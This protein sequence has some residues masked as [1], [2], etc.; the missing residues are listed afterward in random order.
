[1]SLAEDFIKALPSDVQTEMA[2]L[3]AILNDKKAFSVARTF[4]MTV[5][6][7]LRAKKV[8]SRSE[9]EEAGGLNY[10]VSL[11][12]TA[13]SMANMEFHCRIVTEMWMR[14][15]LI[16]V[17]QTNVSRSYDLSFDV[18]DVL[19]KSQGELSKITE[20]LQYRKPVS[21]GELA[22]QVISDMEKGDNDLFYVPTGISDIDN[23]VKMCASDLI[24]LAARPGMGKTSLIVNFMLNLGIAGRRGMFFS[25]EMPSIQIV[26]K[27][28]SLDSGV[29]Y[30]KIRERKCDPY[31]RER[32]SESYGRIKHM[33]SMIN[34][35]SN[36]TIEEIKAL[37]ISENSK[38]PIEYVII[39]FLQTTKPSIKGTRDQEIGHMTRNAKAMAKEL[40]VPVIYLSQLSR[41]VEKRGGDKR[42]VLSDLRDS[43]NIEQD[44]DTVM[45]MYRPEY[46]GINEDEHGGSTK[47]ICEIDFAKNRHGGTG[48]VQVRCRMD[49]GRFFDMN[50]PSDMVPPVE[51]QMDLF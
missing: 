22:F 34:D 16:T 30:W 20:K 23:E 12:N 9:L 41:D 11:A 15:L 21:V 42:P 35:T 2:I 37:A 29:P 38:E 14:R 24:I 5:S 33:T 8:G 40:G 32:L 28:L 47:G 27:M 13:S 31:E 17:S 7:S 19:A 46:Y 43:G 1:M 4:L 50:T 45:F 48:M 36:M 49:I 18:F 51:E 10:L 39:D 26:Q 25:L 6:N 44:A 3:G